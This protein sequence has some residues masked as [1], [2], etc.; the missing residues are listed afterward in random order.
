MN[1]FL[2]KRGIAFFLKRNKPMLDPDA[3]TAELMYGATTEEMRAF[4]MRN[5]IIYCLTVH[6]KPNLKNTLDSLRAQGYGLHVVT[7]RLGAH[8]KDFLGRILRYAVIKKF[9]HHGIYMDSYTFTNDSIADDKLN[10]CRD[11]HFDMIVEDNP[12]H[13][14]RIA[15]NLGIPVIV[16]STP[17]NAGLNLDNIIRIHDLNELENAVK[18]ADLL[19]RNGYTGADS[20]K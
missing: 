10:V 9:E 14:E 1:G 18:K 11:K 17:E 13:I 3:T 4:W 15:S 19:R 20:V 5:Y 16:V 6:L 12:K 7:A 2:K 8:R